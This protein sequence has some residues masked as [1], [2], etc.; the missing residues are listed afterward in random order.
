MEPLLVVAVALVLA[1]AYTNGFH[2]ASNILS[3]VVAS[4]ALPPGRALALVAAFELAGPLLAGT[5]VADTV[6]GFVDLAGVPRPVALQVVLAGVAA[7]SAWNLVTWRWGLP[8]S[9]AHALVGGLAGAVI[10]ALGPQRVIWGLAA[11]R[12]GELA[13]V[14]KVF[15]GLLA[16]PWLA[17]T[18][19]FALHR[20]GRR[21][22]AGARRR[23]AER[24][25]TLQIL[26]SAALAF[27]HGAN[28]AQKSMGVLAL[29]LAAAG[30]A[31]RVEVTPWIVLACSAALTLGILSGGWRIVR[32]LGWGIYRLRPLHALDAQLAS[33]GVILAGSAGGLPVSTTH[34][35]ASAILG[36][37]ASE[38][39]R[40]VRWAV[41]GRILL[42]WALTLPAAAALG[43]G[44]ALVAGRIA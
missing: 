15:A 24:V 22:L 28:D 1:Y 10:V 18:A 20:T 34:V 16:A 17:A 23:T 38:R 26:T 21:L 8:S 43:A 14:V 29:A 42:N 36:V 6:G 5:A 44:G 12:A 2:D 32:T 41:A 39:P 40:R 27:G 31:P 4:R 7:A 13:G 30:A 19:G 3:A 25:R 9:S 33:A 11:L 37:G 35:V